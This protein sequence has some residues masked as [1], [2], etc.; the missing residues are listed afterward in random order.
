MR[1]DFEYDAEGDVKMSAPQPISEVTRASNLEV[2]S[3]ASITTILRERRQYEGKV[4]E[5][6]RVTGEVQAVV[7]RSIRS[8]FE[9]RVLEHVPHYILKM[10][11]AS[12]TDDIPVTVMKRKLAQ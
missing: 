5:Q 3:Q 10:D 8:T 1:D 9:L 6:S 7:T 2:W 4:Q 12:V 11:V